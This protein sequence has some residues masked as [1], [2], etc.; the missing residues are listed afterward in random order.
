MG[1]G[2]RKCARYWPDDEVTHDHIRVKY[3]QSESCPYYT[4]RELCVTNLKV[5]F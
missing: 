1:D 3:I 4:R 5:F 2:L